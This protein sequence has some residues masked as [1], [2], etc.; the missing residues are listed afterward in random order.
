MQVLLHVDAG[1]SVLRLLVHEIHPAILL[2]LLH[3][4][5]CIMHREY[6]VLGIRFDRRLIR[7]IETVQLA[8][9]GL[10]QRCHLLDRR[11]SQQK[12]VAA[13]ETDAGRDRSRVLASAYDNMA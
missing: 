7:M 2:G 10:E 4:L 8:V 1:V 9:D 5:P 13:K 11:F 3:C 6:F 12:H